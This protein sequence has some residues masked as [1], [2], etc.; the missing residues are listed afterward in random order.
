MCKISPAL[1]GRLEQNLHGHNIGEDGD[2]ALIFKVTAELIKSKLSECSG[3]TSVF[4]QN[5]TSFG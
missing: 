1:V 4:S 5:N 2:L 3:K